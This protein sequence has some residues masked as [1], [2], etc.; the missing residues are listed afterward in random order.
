[1]PV[2]ELS[3]Y[4]E[5]LLLVTEPVD[6]RGSRP[7]APGAGAPSPSGPYAATS[8]RRRQHDL[9]RIPRPRRPPPGRRGR[10]TLPVRRPPCS[11]P[12]ARWACTAKSTLTVR[13]IA[14]RRASR[15]E[16]PASTLAL[17]AVPPRRRGPHCRSS[18]GDCRTCERVQL[19]LESQCLRSTDA[20]SQTVARQQLGPGIWAGG[21]GRRMTVQGRTPIAVFLPCTVCPYVVLSA[22]NRVSAEEGIRLP[23]CATTCPDSQE[24]FLTFQVPASAFDNV[25][26]FPGGRRSLPPP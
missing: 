21:V 24:A 2:E 19:R 9:L 6:W 20:G 10:G 5:L 8:M 3:D 26:R 23:R 22:F 14:Q 15:E 17:V 25:S 18:Q 11:H 7:R 1:M 4:R 16:P 12:T 13:I